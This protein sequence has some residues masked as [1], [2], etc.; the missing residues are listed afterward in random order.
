MGANVGIEM[1]GISTALADGVRRDTRTSATFVAG[2]E[3]HRWLNDIFCVCEGAFD[4]ATG[5]STFAVH[6]CLNELT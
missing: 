4:A 6:E 2:A 3:A 5:R 1:H